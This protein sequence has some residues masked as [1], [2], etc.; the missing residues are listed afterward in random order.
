MAA[1]SLR[2]QMIKKMS[3]IYILLLPA[4]IITFLFMYMPMY[5]LLMAFKEYNIID[6]IWHSPWVGLHWFRTIFTEKEFWKVLGYTLFISLSATVFI[7]PV[8]ITFA[9]LLNELRAVK[10]KKLV[11][12]V[13]YLPHFMSWVIIA[14]IF[15]EY[16]LP[17][18]QLNELIYNIFNSKLPFLSDHKYFV[19]VLLTAMIWKNTGFS[20]I[21]Y[22]ATL[23]SI[24]PQLYEAGYIDGANRWQ[25]TWNI[26][27]PSILPTA[28]LL[29]ILGT[30]NLLNV[31]FDMVYNMQNDVI[32]TETHVID[33]YVYYESIRL[34]NFSY[35][36]A[37][38]FFKGIVA[39]FIIGTS[40]FISR[41]FSGIS[42]W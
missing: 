1:S 18:G 4:V 42:L 17:S 33:T 14:G 24:D 21:I 9:L 19:P 35:G 37:I 7:F 10:F 8:P 28:I 39:F 27:I 11:Q 2:K 29:L 25:L 34:G 26:T 22:L 40:N 23:S 41:K 6:G 32:R 13:S 31:G 20:A 36:T 12:T 38:G 16:L 5:G 30:G 15:Y 3:T